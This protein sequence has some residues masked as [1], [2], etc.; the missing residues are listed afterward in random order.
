MNLR[1]RDRK[2][3]D[4]VYMNEIIKDEKKAK[5]PKTARVKK[6]APIHQTESSLRARVLSSEE[7]AQG[8]P[9]K[10]KTGY[11]L[12]H[13]HRVSEIKETLGLK[14]HE[15]FKRAAKDW[16]KLPEKEKEWFNS[17]AQK[18]GPKITR[19]Q[20]V[21]EKR[22]KSKRQ[23]RSEPVHYNYSEHI[24]NNNNNNNSHVYLAH[25]EDMSNNHDNNI[26]NEDFMESEYHH[27]P[28]AIA[29]SPYLDASSRNQHDAQDFEI[30]IMLQGIDPPM[31]LIPTIKSHEPRND[32]PKYCDVCG[33]EL[34][35][36]DICLLCSSFPRSMSEFK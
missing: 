29:F 9:Q 6:K 1:K 19:V 26:N 21:S 13:M 23:Q 15:A 32:N 12:Y 22:G 27:R 14:H 24:N 2:L 10:D 11:Q 18:N 30:D 17:R 5:N 25:G 8:V 31:D 20:R 7:T 4:D 35:W 33:Q 34:P 16:S 3:N 36:Q 28:H